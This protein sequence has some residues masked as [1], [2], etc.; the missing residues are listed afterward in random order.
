ML[1]KILSAS[2][3]R[4]LSVYSGRA[5]V[6]TSKATP[7][8]VFSVS[9][10]A[11]AAVQQP[12]PQ[13]PK[14]SKIDQ[15]LA[16]TVAELEKKQRDKIIMKPNEYFI[17]LERTMRML[18]DPRNGT[19]TNEESVAA[20]IYL[21]VMTAHNM[22]KLT[23]L[24]VV[25]AVQFLYHLSSELGFRFPKDH[26]E[27]ILS[28]IPDPFPKDLE[29]VFPFF[30]KLITRLPDPTAIE[31]IRNRVGT[32]TDKYILKHKDE[33]KVQDIT[34]ILETWMQVGYKSE[35]SLRIMLDH[36]KKFAKIMTFT[37]SDVH[38]LFYF[39]ATQ[40]K[41]H[42]KDYVDILV[43]KAKEHIVGMDLYLLNNLLAFK[44]SL[45]IEDEDFTKSVIEAIRM[46]FNTD[47][48]QLAPLTYSQLLLALGELDPAKNK[49]L[50]DKIV[51]HFV[52]DKTVLQNPSNWNTLPVYLL[53]VG[54]DQ[55][56]T[57][58]KE[59][60]SKVD[61]VVEKA[62]LNMTPEFV[63]PMAK[64]LFKSRFA[65]VRPIITNFAEACKRIEK[66]IKPEDKQALKVIV[67]DNKEFAGFPFQLHDLF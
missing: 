35:E 44:K 24:E 8:K 58:N 52:N 22:P 53:V 43:E 57:D 26:M 46:F 63:V 48:V 38:I 31:S 32:M 7:A 12:P 59:F 28:A 61:E 9:Q 6:S 64:V 14:G 3:A 50:Q 20:L 5:L 47:K 45:K 37:P 29:K 66:N 30:I 40:M 67:G 42:A 1:K 16:S 11:F 49:D 54:T 55:I 34:S 56:K 15:H 18:E 21:C 4:A 27:S 60:Y 62:I 39:E 41:E 36:L 13:P 2:F 10:R 17:Q 23:P 65:K 33:L 19:I 25:R 51:Q